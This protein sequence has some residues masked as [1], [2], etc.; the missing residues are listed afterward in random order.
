MNAQPSMVPAIPRVAR[1]LSFSNQPGDVADVSSPESPLW[2][3]PTEATEIA[4]NRIATN[5]L[6]TVVLLKR[7]RMIDRAS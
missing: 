6:V 3:H 4:A 5:V 1:Y 7:R 2:P